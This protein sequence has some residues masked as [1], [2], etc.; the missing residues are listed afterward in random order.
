MTE[1]YLLQ[2]I[3]TNANLK[4]A[5]LAHADL[6]QVNLTGAN[7]EQANLTGAKLDRATAIGANFLGA[8]LTDV[9]IERADFTGAIMPDGTSYDQW[10]LK[11]PSVI[12]TDIKTE[13]SREDLSQNP[14]PVRET[15]LKPVFIPKKVLYEFIPQRR[16]KRYPSNIWEQLS[17]QQGDRFL[18]IF[19]LVFFFG[20]LGLG[21]E[22]AFYQASWFLWLLAWAGSIAWVFH[23]AFTWFAPVSGGLAVMSSMM[24]SLFVYILMGITI[25]VSVIHLIRLGFEL[26]VALRDGLWLGGVVG[27]LVALVL[28]QFSINLV[29]SVIA[30]C[31]GNL[32]WLMMEEINFRKK[33]IYTILG[34]L[35]GL[36]LSLGGLLQLLRNIT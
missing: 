1:A 3:L 4:F 9:D 23:E 11:H 29:L 24:L 15:T 14:T 10:I 30:I 31:L 5:N 2:A 36:G 33:E 7:L 19:L 8:N 28:R 25:L 13:A 20:Y 12:K 17:W 32:S 16:R 22:L 27:F 6:T 35:S 26:R 18:L 21:I 34:S